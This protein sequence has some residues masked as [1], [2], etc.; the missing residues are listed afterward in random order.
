[1]VMNLRKHAGAIA[2][3]TAYAAFVV[4]SFLADFPPGKEVFG[5][6]WDFLKQM[7]RMLPCVFILIGLFDAWVK[8]STV[9]AHLGRHSGG[10]AYVWAILLAGTTVGGFY[11][12]LPV[13]HA[14]YYKGA[15][16]GVVLAYLSGAAICRVPM[17]LFEAS[18]LGWRFTIIRFAV[19]L[20]LVVLSSALL[21]KYL[22]RADY[23]MPFPG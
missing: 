11:V 3:I 10:L 6:F 17:T 23:R 16:L 4:C 19:S 18:F 20:P 5:N 15:K 12:A 14:L 1:M 8:R 2:L 13:G 21:G 22:E 9:E 7:L